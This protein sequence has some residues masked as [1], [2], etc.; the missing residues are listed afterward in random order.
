MGGFD[1][2]FA[3]GQQLHGQQFQ[4]AEEQRI[5]QRDAMANLHQQVI[6]NPGSTPE[7][8]DQALN[9]ISAL[10]KPHEAPD[11]FQ[12]LAG[13]IHGQKSQPAAEVQTAEAAPT[14]PQQPQ[15]PP[16]LDPLGIPYSNP[17]HA[18]AATANPTPHPFAP[19]TPEHPVNRIKEGLEALGGFLKQHGQGFSQPTAPAPPT[20]SLAS[21]FS[22]FKTP[23]QVGQDT[24]DA[25]Q[26]RAIALKEEDLKRYKLTRTP[27]NK[28]LDEYAGT[29]YGLPSFSDL[30]SDQQAEAIAAYKKAN[31]GVKLT[32][33]IV[34]DPD[35]S[36]GFS[37][38]TYNQMTGEEQSTIP[39]AIPPRGY[40]PTKRVTRT[41][42]PA[43]GLTTTS[44]SDVT[45]QVPGVNAAPIGK[46]APKFPTNVLTPPNPNVRP[47]APQA[48]AQAAGAQATQGGL[49]EVNAQIA[50][51]KGKAG[52]P[53]R[54]AARMPVSSAAPN[55]ASAVP[56]RKLDEEGNIPYDPNVPTVVLEAARQ[57]IDGQDVNKIKGKNVANM[58]GDYARQF[59]W[60]QG[61]F[62]P[63]EQNQ[64]DEAKY[65]LTQLRNDPSLGV[66]DSF[67]DRVHLAAVPHGTK[68]NSGN[69]LSNVLGVGAAMTE[70][71]LQSQYQ[72][73]IDQANNIAGG[74]GQLTR[75][76]RQTEA[77]LNR[78]RDE[79]PN[80][81]RAKNRADAERRIDNLLKEIEIAE[82]KYGVPAFQKPHEAKTSPGGPV[83][84][85][86]PKSPP[87]SG[88]TLKA[89]DQNGVMHW[90]N[91]DGEDLG[92]V[93]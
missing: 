93:Q 1:Q 80:V 13:L 77:G 47:S 81:L 24:A 84:K 41:T 43:T 61:K 54:K 73:N 32:T 38:A 40:V 74:I 56:I 71:D 52:A 51:N 45:P 90:T 31:V 36:T 46:N 17:D 42:D 26:T 85:N 91:K 67:G 9:A 88:A 92:V 18:A 21:E 78:V 5:A 3:Y 50:A 11:L 14:E 15:A 53:S 12:R 69:L 82:R 49:D 16:V 19:V 28:F 35:S 33:Q 8:R 87:P 86:A 79:M 44:V 22:G 62:T 34:A 4:K 2:G 59:G 10:Y 57:L 76:G 55:P 27:Q 37:K 65:F 68:A 39:G 29:N 64:M 48:A 58:A 75:S 70:S 6:T 20:P 7:Q 60:S 23:Y 30:N 72:S 89:P 66:L 63:R 25:Q 83:S